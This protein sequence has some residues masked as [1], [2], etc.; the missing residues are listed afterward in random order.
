[1]NKF[2][3]YVKI[4]ILDALEMRFQLLYWLYVNMAP[5]IMMTYLWSHL[6]GQKSDIGGYT[7]NM[8]VTYYLMTR[9]INRIISTYAEERIAKDI[10]EGRLNQ[11][12]TRPIDYMTYKF[13]ERIGIRAVNLLIVVPVYLPLMLILQKYLIFLRS[14]NHRLLDNFFLLCS[15]SSLAFIS[16]QMAFLWLRHTPSMV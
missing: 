10:K 1:M 3:T 12:I 8:M 15:F 14:R 13:G 6:Y 16:A 2:A 9:L 11:Y 7:L 4:G 5:I